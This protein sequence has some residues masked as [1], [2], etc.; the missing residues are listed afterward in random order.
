[1]SVLSDSQMGCTVAKAH[2]DAAVTATQLQCHVLV[3]GVQRN[4]HQNKAAVAGAVVGCAPADGSGQSRI[5]SRCKGE[6]LRR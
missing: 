4:I 6:P 2:H 3:Q 1:M 5:P